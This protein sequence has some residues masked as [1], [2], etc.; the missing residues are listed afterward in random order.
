MG[1][2][3]CIANQK[4]GVGK[5]TTAVNFSTALAVAEKDSLLIDCDPLGHATSGMGIKKSRVAKTLYHGLMGDAAPEELIIKSELDFL[6][7]LPAS[8]ELLRAESE[9]MSRPDKEHAL[10][11]FISGL[12]D[13]YD[14]IVIDSPPS[15]SLLAVNALIA[16]DSLLIPL[17]CEYYALEGMGHLLKS[18][19]ILKNK[20]NPEMKIAGILLTMFEGEEEVSRKIAE[21]ARFHFKDKVF[22]TVIPRTVQLRESASHGKPLLLH[23]M[24]SSGAQSYLALAGEF[25]GKTIGRSRS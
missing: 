2:V 17:Q 15:M 12:K 7:I 19:Q 3:I 16:A 4:G 9:L 23:D 18:T 21:M 22:K 20:F 11:N 6:K 25:I 8:A 13:R 5:T 24:R 14:Y 10:K 1:H